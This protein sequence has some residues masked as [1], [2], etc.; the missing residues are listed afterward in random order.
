MLHVY[1]R[2]RLTLEAELR[3]A[4]ER[5]ELRLQYQPRMA[6]M[7]DRL[8][9][10]EALV[11]WMH[12][13]YG[14]LAPTA[15]IPLAEETGLIVPL[16]TAMLIEACRQARLWQRQHPTESALQVNVNLSLRQFWDPYLVA[17]VAQTL[18]ASELP[19]ASLTLE[20]TESVAIEN[21][22][23]T[24]TKLHELKALGVR[25]ALDDFGS[26]FSSLRYLQQLPVDILKID[27]AFIA[28]IEGDPHAQQIVRAIIAL[29]HALGIRV[30]GEGVETAG[31]FE[32][33]ARLECDLVQGYY[34]SPPVWA[35]AAEALLASNAPRL[36][37][38]PQ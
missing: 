8:M 10:F 25:L 38:L 2:Q 5:G 19:P 3:G 14:M 6:P 24:I 37:M 36:S 21:A 29:A 20:I 23:A 32:Q 4:V 13:T 28:R 12:P 31:Q 33:L 9:G 7:T 1:A 11:R 27:R 30:V 26:G 15:F 16:G 35:D 17:T 18:I 22:E 34:L